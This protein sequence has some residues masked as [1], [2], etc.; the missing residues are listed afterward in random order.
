MHNGCYRCDWRRQPNTDLDTKTIRDSNLR[1]RGNKDFGFSFVRN[2]NRAAPKL[3]SYGVECKDFVCIE[4]P[5]NWLFPI[6]DEDEHFNWFFRRNMI[7]STI[8]KRKYECNSLFT[9]RLLTEL[10]LTKQDDN[11]KI[12]PKIGPNIKPKWT[13][14][15]FAQNK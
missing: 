7:V 9:R 8:W 4:L 12:T 5:P 13:F 11:R 2:V 10:Y 3:A 15:L 14:S 6:L 1:K